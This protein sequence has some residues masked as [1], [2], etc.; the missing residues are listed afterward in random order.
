MGAEFKFA[1]PRFDA[2]A[3]AVAGKA[4]GEADGEAAGKA[5]IEASADQRA[6]L[7]WLIQR[8]VSLG[9][10]EEAPLYPDGANWYFT[11]SV[12]AEPYLFACQSEQP[13]DPSAGTV[14]SLHVVAQRTFIDK[15]LGRR[16]LTEDNALL[17]IVM[18][19]LQRE[20][21]FADVTMTLE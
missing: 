8:L 18:E 11:A 14:W 20:S 7:G 6:L 2:D 1:T 13:A 10:T 19:W 15:L 21:D 16:E 3:D 9:L 12:F 17:R 5:D 4:D